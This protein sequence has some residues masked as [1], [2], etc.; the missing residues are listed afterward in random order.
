MRGHDEGGAACSQSKQAFA[1]EGGGFGVEMGSGLVR[2]NECAMW[3]H[4]SAGQ[5]QPQG[6]AARQAQ[7][8]VAND[9]IAAAVVSIPSFELF[10]KQTDRYRYG[11]LGDS[12]RI[13]IEAGIAQGWHEWLRH[14]DRFIGMTGFGASA[15]AGKLYEHFGITTAKVVEAAKGLVG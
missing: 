7:A 8:T 13:A 5:R 1:Y 6:F 3:M 11:V 9:G 15:P 2:Q 12:P 10:R 14:K 4:G